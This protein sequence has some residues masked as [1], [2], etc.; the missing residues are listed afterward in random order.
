MSLLSHLPSP[1][2]LIN[3][4]IPMKTITT[5]LLSASL[6]LSAIGNSSACTALM[7]K[8]KS[9][10]AYQARTMEWAGALPE[11]LNYFPAGSAVQSQTPDGKPGMS[12]K[13]KHAFVAVSIKH[14][15]ED[16]KKVTVAEGANDQ[17]MSLSL[18]AFP[19]NSAQKLDSDA[20][21]VLSVLDFGAWALGNFQNVAQ[22]KQAIQNGE[23]SIWLPSIA[24]LGNV[25]APVHFALFDKTGAGIVVEFN[26]GK[27]NVH[28]NPVG[29]MTNAPDFPWH[30]K[31]LNNYAQL[32]NIDRNNATFGNLK[33]SAPDSGNALAG[34]PSTQISSGRFVKAAFY[35]TFVRKAKTPAE[36]ILTISHVINNFDRPYD[37][38]LD[39]PGTT[40]GPEDQNA[41]ATNTEVTLFTAMNDLSQNH[42]YLR[43][44]NGINFSMIDL[45]KLA[46]VKEIKKVPFGK[47]DQL[48]GA[49]ATSL[50]LN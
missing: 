28:D 32:S 43:T 9:G 46:G 8:D 19:D 17:G 21:K 44:I 36:A 38:S 4:Q 47:F 40:S 50:F 41:K 20:N 26:S 24:F 12:F 13:T 23:V 18:L 1:L 16:P 7:M 39:L 29:V 2:L 33:V 10:K 6:A 14:L 31:N 34:L 3:E 27:I 30:L 11:G 22:V 25:M 45:S 42:F 37:L 49:D 5:A 48:N 15:S 35:T